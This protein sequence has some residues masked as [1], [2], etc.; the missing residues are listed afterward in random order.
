MYDLIIIGAGPAGLSAGLYA[1]RFRLNTLI[2]ERVSAGGQIIL[3]STIE[4]YPGFPAGISTTELIERFKKQ[5]EDV[6]VKIEYSEVLEISLGKDQIYNIKTSEGSFDTRSVIIAAGAQS[7][8]LGVE[9]EERF[10]G[11]GVSYC[12]TCDGPLFKNKDV[13]VVGGGD[14]AIEEALFLSSYAAKVT[15]IHRRQE[16][17]A[18]KILE[19]KARQNLKIN[20]VLKSVIEKIIGSDRVEGVVIKN[21]ETIAESIL[22][23]HGL[24]IFVGLVPDTQFLKNLLHLDESGF[25]ITD[26]NMASSKEGIFASGDCRKKGLYQVITA[27]AEGAIATNSVH[28]YLMNK[29]GG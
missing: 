14:R 26:E 6:G 3:S 10:L 5:T 17:R 23:C 18:S 27:C 19:E 21:R 29:L 9:G 11:R 2:L 12:A 16:L 20:F 22:S 8:R 7:K 24:F 25:I 13:V 4:N 28:N 1:G 15:I